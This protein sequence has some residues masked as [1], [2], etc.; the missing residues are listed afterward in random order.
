MDF[1]VFVK[2]NMGQCQSVN[3]ES[4]LRKLGEGEEGIICAD[5]NFKYVRKYPTTGQYLFRCEK[6]AVMKLIKTHETL[7]KKYTLIDPSAQ[8]N[9]C[10][11]RFMNCGEKNG[12]TLLQYLENIK[13]NEEI[14]KTTLIAVFEMIS[15]FHKQNIYHYD[16]HLQ[17]IL[18]C[19]SFN[20]PFRI[21]DFSSTIFENTPNTKMEVNDLAVLLKDL[22]SIKS[23][24]KGVYNILSEKDL[25]GL[26]AE[27]I[28]KQLQGHHGGSTKYVVVLSR[29]RK[30]I[31][32]NNKEYVNVKGQL[33]TLQKAY[34]MEQKLK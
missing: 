14:I 27:G 18:H 33:I 28:V 1:F 12:M 23:F 5:S 16:L 11:L 19:P 10:Y 17:N 15:E 26:T 2:V 32:K 6:Q 22:D 21:I 25:E 20:P 29:K 24:N 4:P 30:I 7:V 8:Q 13:E 31:N 34:K 3:A 9:G